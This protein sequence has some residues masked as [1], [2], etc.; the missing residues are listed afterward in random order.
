[1]NYILILHVQVLNKVFVNITKKCLSTTGV[2]K[3]RLAGQMRPS[4]SKSVAR[5]LLFSQKHIS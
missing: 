5:K 3:L 4:K 1:M 2:G